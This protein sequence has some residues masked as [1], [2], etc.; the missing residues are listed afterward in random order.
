MFMSKSIHVF[1]LYIYSLRRMMNPPA[2]PQNTTVPPITDNRVPEMKPNDMMYNDSDNRV[3]EVMPPQNDLAISDDESDDDDENET[4]IPPIESYPLSIP[5]EKPFYYYAQLEQ[6]NRDNIL[7]QINLQL[8]DNQQLNH[9]MEPG[10]QMGGD[11]D[12]ATE[13][14]NYTPGLYGYFERTINRFTGTS[15]KPTNTLYSSF[16]NVVNGVLGRKPDVSNQVIDLTNG[17]NATGEYDR[18]PND[19]TIGPEGLPSTEDNDIPIPGMD[20]DDDVSDDS[21]VFGNLEPEPEPDNNTEDDV[22]AIEFI[23][24]KLPGTKLYYFAKRNKQFWV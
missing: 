6:F 23:E 7:P 12:A 17:R 20:D 8:S 21:T 1:T 4:P 13:S 16:S 15:D 19:L 9:D 10:E 2:V 18:S 5:E 24:T 11:A 14:A 22:K 3:P